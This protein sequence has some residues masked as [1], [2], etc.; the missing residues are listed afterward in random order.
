[1]EAVS[2]AVAATAAVS[3]EVDAVAAA[4][5]ASQTAF[6][7]HDG[8]IPFG[9]RRQGEVIA[10]RELACEMTGQPSAKVIRFIKADAHRVQ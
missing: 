6:V 7:L 4:G 5:K 1:M 3:E 8:K 2:G 9:V 10:L